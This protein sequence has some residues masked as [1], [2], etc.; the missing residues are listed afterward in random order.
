MSDLVDSFEMA[1]LIITHN[2][3]VVASVCDRVA[4][5]YAGRIVEQ[6]LTRDLFRAPLHPYTDLLLK[7]TP[8]LG[9]RELN[10][11]AGE[12]KPRDTTGPAVGCAFRDRC[13]LV[14]AR[15]AEQPPLF[16]ATATRSVRC[17]VAQDDGRPQNGSNSR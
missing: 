4:V 13:P 14:E 12:H 7:S 16:Q 3:G 17:W 6:G 1:L 8:R 10:R 2:M 9:H 5:M 11:V 15:C